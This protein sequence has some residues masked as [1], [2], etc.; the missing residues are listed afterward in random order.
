MVIRPLSNNVL[1]HIEQTLLDT[2]T[3]ESGFKLYLIPEYNFEQNST[4]TGTIYNLPKDYDGD[5]NI[6]DEVAF[7][8]KVVSDRTF[9]NTADFF[10]PVADD[11]NGYVR[12]WANH[13][14][15][16]LRMMAHEGAISIFWVGTYFDKNGNFQYGT[17][18]TE[19][20][21]ERWMHNN[22]KF[23][24]CENFIFKNRITIDDTHYWKCSIENIFAK[25][26]GDEI[27]STGDRII[28]N[29]I[30]VPID[31]RIL[32]ES[33]IDLPPSAVQ[34]RYYDRA[35]VLNGGE[36]LG[37]QKGDIVS[38]EEKYV[39]KYELWGK[40]YF[41]IKKRRVLGTWENKAA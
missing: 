40:N 1:L 22:F 21:V 4:I 2:I 20:Q 41:L 13:K 5:L 32:R 17:Q 6:G 8:Y 37:F 24:N 29:H 14:G 33:G 23:G 34:M 15:E 27:I 12:M 7:S 18:G 30:D 19:S 26:Q 3:T 36:D 38:F 28:C 10:V 35:T 31:A 9:P 39:E 11:M 16:R 25:K